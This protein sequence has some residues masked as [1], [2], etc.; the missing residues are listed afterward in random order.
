MTCP[1]CSV[2]PED[3]SG[4]KYLPNEMQSQFHRRFAELECRGL[5]R[6]FVEGLTGACP[7]KYI[8]DVERSGFNRGL[9]RAP[10]T[11]LIVKIREIFIYLW[12]SPLCPGSYVENGVGLQYFASICQCEAIVIFRFLFLRNP[13]LTPKCGF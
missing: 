12:T 11:A 5:A 2:A 4:V 7:V 1:A 3:V 9:A 6:F 13:V 8:E 10:F